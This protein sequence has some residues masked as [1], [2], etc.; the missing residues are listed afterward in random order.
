MADHLSRLVR[1]EEEL[2]L[3]ETFPDEQLFGI[4]VNTPWY[5][6]IVNYIV[7]NEFPHTLSHAQKEKLKRTVWQYEWD[8]PYLWKHCTDQLIRRCVP[9][10]EHKSVLT[11]CTLNHVEAILVLV[12]QP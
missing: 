5:A 4:Q 7:T 11:F 1:E 3:K 12:G 2:P 9:D 10:I 6:D 8:D